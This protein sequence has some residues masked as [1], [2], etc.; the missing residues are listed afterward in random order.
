MF[1]GET[2]LQLE[3]FSSLN[4]LKIHLASQIPHFSESRSI[5]INDKASQIN[6]FVNWRK[7][8]KLMASENEFLFFLENYEFYFD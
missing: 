3:I 7:S 6:I 2:G 4:A 1:E 5:N 8:K